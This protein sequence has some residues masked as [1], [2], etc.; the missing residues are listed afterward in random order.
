MRMENVSILRRYY[1][2]VRPPGGDMVGL[3]LTTMAGNVPYMLTRCSGRGR[4][5]HVPVW[6]LAAYIGLKAFSKAGFWLNFRITK[7]LLP[8]H[9]SA[10]A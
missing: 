7:C 2:A 10:F 8:H 6:M 4:P 5:G 3:F 1:R 9:L